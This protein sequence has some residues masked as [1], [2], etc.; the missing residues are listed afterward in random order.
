MSCSEHLPVLEACRSSFLEVT[1]ADGRQKK[2]VRFPGRER[3]ALEGVVL[4]DHSQSRVDKLAPLYDK[5]QEVVVV[6]GGG[7]SLLFLSYVCDSLRVLRDLL[8]QE[9]VGTALSHLSDEI[10]MGKGIESEVGVYCGVGVRISSVGVGLL[11]ARRKRGDNT[12]LHHRGGK[13]NGGV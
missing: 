11:R 2:K 5:G 7:C 9:A 3:N 4:I 6:G 8:G 12:V 10:G 13:G 1:P